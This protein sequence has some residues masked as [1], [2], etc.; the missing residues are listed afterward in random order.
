V[1]VVGDGDLELLD[2]VGCALD[3]GLGASLLLSPLSGLLLIESSGGE[4]LP[5]GVEAEV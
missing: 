1:F 2:V 3:V 5:E 4:I